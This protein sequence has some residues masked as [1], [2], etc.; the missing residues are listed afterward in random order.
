[1][2]PC[3]TELQRIHKVEV[4]PAGARPPSVDRGWGAAEIGPKSDSWNCWLI[5]IFAGS[6]AVIRRADGKLCNEEGTKTK[7]VFREGS[8]EWQR[9]LFRWMVRM[10]CF[11]LRAQQDYCWARVCRPFCLQHLCEWLNGV[12][13]RGV[14]CSAASLL[15]FLSLIYC[16]VGLCGGEPVRDWLTHLTRL[17]DETY[18]SIVHVQRILLNAKCHDWYSSSLEA[19]VQSGASSVLSCS[20]FSVPCVVSHLSFCCAECFFMPDCCSHTSCGSYV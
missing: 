16:N 3:T 5:S 18:P 20:H 15:Q 12:L 9:D 11:Q 10:F 1:M 8:W 13:M 7:A 2:L 19:R 17:E 14:L 6:R 4:F